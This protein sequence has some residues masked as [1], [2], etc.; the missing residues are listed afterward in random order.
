MYVTMAGNPSTPT[1]Y[2]PI[3]IFDP[4]IWKQVLAMNLGTS[5]WPYYTYVQGAT[6][7]FAPIPGSS[8]NIITFRGR[9]QNKELQFNDYTTGT[10][11]S[12]ANGGTAVVGSGTTWTKDMIGRYIQI[13]E[14]TAANGGDG[15]WYEIGGW[16][17]ATHIALL[18]PYE[19][20]AIAAGSA[21]YTIGQMSNIPE[22]YDIAPAYRSAA[23]Y[24][25]NQNDLVRAKTYWMQYDGGVEA[26]YTKDYGGIMLQM[27][28]TEMETEEGGFVMPINAMGGIIQAPYYL[29]YQQATGFS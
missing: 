6:V 20:T 10:I 14:T 18:K 12:V 21:A 28:E 26:G 23:L 2:M 13:T 3:M 1:V 19:G 22:A 27:M 4:T 24:W 8:G 5:D 9:L 7:Q 11:V 16:T 17:D 29:P 25:Q 15:Y